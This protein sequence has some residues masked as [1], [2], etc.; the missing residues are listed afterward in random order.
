MYNTGKHDERQRFY[1][2]LELVKTFCVPQSGEKQVNLG[3]LFEEQEE[4]VKEKKRL[5]TKVENLESQVNHLKWATLPSLRLSPNGRASALPQP[6]P[7]SRSS[8]DSRGRKA[9][10]VTLSSKRQRPEA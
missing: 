9:M 8:D 7:R 1:A 4:L 2:L 3:H 6:D 10:E 5:E